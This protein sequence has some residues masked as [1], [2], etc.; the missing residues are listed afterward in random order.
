MSE[1]LIN[2]IDVLVHPEFNDM[3]DYPLPFVEREVLR[4]RWMNRA[5]QAGSNTSTALFYYSNF[6]W[7][8]KGTDGTSKTWIDHKGNRR[9][10]VEEKKRIK[11]MR[12]LF[13]NRLVLLSGKSEPHRNEVNDA[14][15]KRGLKIQAN[16]TVFAYGE[17]L[18]ACVNKW[19]IA[20]ASAFNI[21]KKKVSFPPELCLGVNGI[22]INQSEYERFSP[23]SPV[24]GTPPEACG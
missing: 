17:Y 18:G 7:H 24:T 22:T 16:A 5:Q 23:D 10:Y 13:G 21:P 3:C 19:G 11:A 2:H 12:K 20:T 8:R 9:L 1:G 14:T 15:E 6:I 4:Q